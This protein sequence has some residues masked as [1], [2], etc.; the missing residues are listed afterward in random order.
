[1]AQVCALQFF[2]RAIVDEDKKAWEDYMRIC[3]AGGTKSF[4]ETI[5]AAHL[6]SPFKKG[7][8]EHVIET[9]DKELEKT[10]DK[11]L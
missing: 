10:D 8:L 2:K 7:S 3:E 1:M 9:I 11:K 6:Q 4:L 5:E